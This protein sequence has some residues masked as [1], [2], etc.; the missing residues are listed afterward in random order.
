MENHSYDEVIGSKSAPYLN[1]LAAACGVAT[2]YHNITHPSLPNYIAATSGLDGRA[3]NP[4]FDDC[5][6][7]QTCSTAAKS[8]F[9]DTHRWRAY[10]ESM[11][12]PCARQDSGD[13]AVRHNPPPFYT[14]LVGCSRHDRPLGDLPRDL[15]RNALPAF[16]FITPNLCH[17]THDCTVDVGDRWL[18]R[19]V[20][21]ILNSRQYRAGTVA[22]FITWDE[23]EGG[24]ATDCATNQR[25]IGCHVAMVIISPSTPSGRRSAR[26]FNHYSLLR[27]T[28]DL[29]GLAPLGKARAASSMAATFGL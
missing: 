4:F 28:E 25:D 26:V 21:E 6:P 27:T 7:S 24:S 16:S 1:S 11:P 15:A 19:E 17:D 29:L 13:Y 22:L 20:P 5:D 12:A 8:I 3:L 2:N 9:A 14:T 18:A 23:G 10:E